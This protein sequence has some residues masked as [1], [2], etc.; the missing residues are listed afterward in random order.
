MQVSRSFY[1][2]GGVIIGSYGDVSFGGV[3]NYAYVAGRI[4]SCL[5]TRDV[6]SNSLVI[7][8]EPCARNPCGANSICK[9]NDLGSTEPYTCRCAS[10]FQGKESD[11]SLPCVGKLKG[12][13]CSHEWKRY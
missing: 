6:L 9:N 2:D 10:G 4:I 5:S 13:V 7:V 12:S 3:V 1:R 8:I 11:Q